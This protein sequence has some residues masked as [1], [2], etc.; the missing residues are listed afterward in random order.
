M[1]DADAA[2][3]NHGWITSQIPPVLQTGKYVFVVIDACKMPLQCPY[4]FSHSRNCSA[5]TSFSCWTIMGGQII[6]WSPSIA[7]NLL[8]GGWSWGQG[9]WA[10]DVS[11]ETAHPVTLTCISDQAHMGTLCQHRWLNQSSLTLI[12]TTVDWGTCSGRAV[13]TPER[14]LFPVALATRRGL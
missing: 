6:I 11:I 1:I 13:K 8:S 7:S 3:P 14:F 9:W 10:D 5:Q 2:N 12:G 4:E